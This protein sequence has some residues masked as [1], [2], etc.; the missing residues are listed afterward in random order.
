MNSDTAK[1]GTAAIL[2]LG[3]LTA[4]GPVSIDMYLPALPA[5]AS[6]LS[7]TSEAAQRTLAVTF[8]GFALGQLLM[9]PLSDRFGRRV[10]LVCGSVAYVLASAG[11]ALSSDIDQMTWLRLCQALA[12]SSGAVVSR[13]V[14]R[15]SFDKA[16]AAKVQSLIMMIMSAAPL[17][18]P[19]IGGYVLNWFGWRTI[20]WILAAFGA[21]CIVAVAL[22][23]P[24][25]HPYDRRT[26]GSFLR[27]FHDYLQVLKNRQAVGYILTGS[28]AFAGMFAFFAGSPFVYIKIYGIAPENY[29]F[30]F[31]ANVVLMV[32][33]SYLNSRI[34]VR[35][36]TQKMLL[37][38]TSVIAASGLVLL[39]NAY[40]GF[41][42]LMG[43]FIPILGCVGTLAMVGANSVA[44]TLSYFTT[45]AGTA[46]AVFGAIQFGSGAIAAGL[47]GLLDDGTAM[48]M[49]IVMAG[50]GLSSLAAFL[51]VVKRENN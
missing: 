9:G 22:R 43:I 31:G 3:L 34:V 12:G 26:T 27:V 44:N 6:D 29:G 8:I 48:P 23:L 2:V 51:F 19:F 18:A 7:A 41:G 5:I 39:F 50:C 20:F 38:G 32:V 25:S 37:I 47:V 13:A 1:T 21:V 11:C 4:Y 24:E 45:I 28:F 16:E 10:V 46:S 14:V 33:F 49:A 36:G 30:L 42:G 17:L 15:D 35:V 40:S